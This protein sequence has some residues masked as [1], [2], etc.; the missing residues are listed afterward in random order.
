M[1]RTI[2]AAAAAAVL[3]MPAAA[4]ELRIGFLNT[5]TGGGA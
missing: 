3:A 1:Q 4:Q 2:L 5:T